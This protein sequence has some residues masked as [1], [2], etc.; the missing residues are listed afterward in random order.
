MK[1][2][3]ILDTTRGEHRMNTIQALSLWSD[4]AFGN[5]DAFTDRFC[6]GDVMDIVNVSWNESSMK[7]VYVLNSGRHIADSFSIDEWLEFRG[8]HM[9]AE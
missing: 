9:D 6:K 1:H 4:S 5:I 3:F 8:D 2:K 7:V